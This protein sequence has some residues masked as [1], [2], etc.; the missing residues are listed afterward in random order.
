MREAGQWRLMHILFD[1]AREA[2]APPRLYAG[3]SDIIVAREVAD[4]VSALDRVRMGL[5][6]GKHAAGYLAFEAGHAFDPKLN[7]SAR[8]GE[9]PLLCFGLFD[10]Y[11]VP[12]LAGLLPSP[13]GAYVGAPMPRT[14]QAA[15]E[16]A[17]GEVR[18]HL[19]AGDF[20]QANL[21]FGCDV[22][23]AGDPLALYGRLRRSALAGWGGIVIHD[24]AAIVSLSPEQFF[25]IR[26]GIIEARPMK[27]TAPRHS[28]PS[29]D[30]AEAQQLAADEKQRAENLMIVDL[31]RNDLARVSVAGSVEVPELFSVETYPTVH[32][33]VSRIT[34]RLREGVDAIDV[35]RTIFPCGS[36]TGAPKIA[37]IEALVLLELEPRGAYT[38]SM[39]WI[40]PGGNA[41]FNVLI[42]T[43]EW[44]MGATKARLGLGS[45]LVVDSVPSNEW[46]ECLLKGDFVRRESQDFDLI[47][48]MGFDPSEGII[49]LDRH[50]DRMRNSAADLDFNFDRHAARNELQ[51]AT[52]GRKQRAMVRLLLS[53]SGAMAIQVQPYDDPEETPVTVAVRP[54]P[55]DP[56]DFRL[57]YK[58]TDRRFLD[59]ARQ[60]DKAWETVFVDPDG[61]LTEGSRTSI[62]VERDGKL[63]TP[64]LSRGLMPGILRAKLIEEGRAQEAELVPADLEGDFYVGNIVRGLVPARL[65]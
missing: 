45:G 46:A 56:T 62:F 22:A 9:G 53:Q 63:L 30:E 35:L 44:Q 65:A 4:V 17:V 32:Q 38:G 10:R 25:T 14:T 34:A 33:M 41:A 55:V 20:Y 61:Q 47:E 40:E 64:P 48:T 11:E 37:A 1:D 16:A 24:D 18:D 7:G 50:L 3:P 51:A 13:D 52:F 26:D 57:R 2:G 19:F 29:A 43:L 42:R 15:Y 60:Q 28:D 27:G 8:R 6:D 49:E 54:L 12:D 58:T 23:V 39:G 31:M 59:Q 36:V 21:T 5:A